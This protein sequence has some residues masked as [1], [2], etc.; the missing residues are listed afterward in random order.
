M[1]IILIHLVV[2]GVLKEM[3]CDEIVDKADVINDDNAPSFKYKASV[4][5]N[6]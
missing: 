6:T 2:Y 4:I 3:R 5:G 1:T